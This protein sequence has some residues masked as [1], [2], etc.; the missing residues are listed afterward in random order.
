MGVGTGTT[1]KHFRRE[2]FYRAANT[3]VTPPRKNP[4]LFSTF[5]VCSPIE[6]QVMQEWKALMAETDKTLGLLPANN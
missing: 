3:F 4:V 2:I 6:R 5:P 1:I